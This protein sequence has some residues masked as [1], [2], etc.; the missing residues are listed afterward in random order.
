[1]IALQK[2][3]TIFFISSKNLKIYD[4]I[5]CLN[6]NLITRFVW[7]LEKEI[8]YDIETLSTDRELNKEHFYGKI[9]QKICT[10]S[11]PQTPF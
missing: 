1:M 11:K 8:R 6:K 3:M 9:M 7:H 10:K 4:V 5:N 2:T